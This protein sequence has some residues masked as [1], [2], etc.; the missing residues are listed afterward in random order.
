MNTVG[1]ARMVFNGV[2]PTLLVHRRLRG[3][4]QPNAGLVALI[5]DREAREVDLTTRFHEQNFFGSD[6]SSITWLKD[7]VDRTTSALLRHSGIDRPLSWKLFSWYN[8]NRRGDHHG[9]HTHPKSYLSGTYYVRVPPAPAALDD[10]RARPGCISF[11][12]P[13]PGA[14]MITIGTE[15][16][17]RPVHV[18]CPRDGTLLMWPSPLLHYVHPNLSEALRISISFN[19]VMDG[20]TGIA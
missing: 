12:D 17:A 13:R 10:S 20:N 9:P 2:W 5:L 1:A 8:V 16:D 15:P 6:E 11:Y 19:V 14:N 3:F 18:M 7:Q 4:E